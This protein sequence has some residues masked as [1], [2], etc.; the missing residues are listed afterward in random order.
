MGQIQELAVKRMSKCWVRGLQDMDKSNN[1]LQHTQW[2]QCGDQ[3]HKFY[4]QKNGQLSKL[5]HMVQFQYSKTHIQKN[6]KEKYFTN[7]EMKN[8]DWQGM[9]GVISKLWMLIRATASKYTHGWLPTQAFLH[10][11]N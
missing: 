7:D 6:I 5:R 3:I 1:Q 2:S 4:L 10:N 9:N 8:I 11:Q